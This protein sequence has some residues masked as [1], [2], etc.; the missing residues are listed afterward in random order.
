MNRKTS[1]YLLP[2]VLV[3]GLLFAA[4]ASADPL[5]PTS[6]I[7]VNAD[8]EHVNAEDLEVTFEATDNQGFASEPPQN[9]YTATV[10]DHT[11]A[12]VDAV[13]T[14]YQ[15]NY[16]I[17]ADTDDTLPVELLNVNVSFATQE[18]V[19]GELTEGDID[20]DNL[21]GST[22]VS[23]LR[24]NFGNGAGDDADLDEDDI[25][26]STDVSLIRTNFGESFTPAGDDGSRSAN[27]GPDGTATIRWSPTAIDDVPSGTVVRYDVFVDNPTGESI[28]TVQIHV[29]FDG[30]RLDYVAAR[31]GAN[32]GIGGG[33]QAGDCD[34]ENIDAMQTTPGDIG[35][36][37]V[38]A[39]E[40]FY[41]FSS[42]EFETGAAL[43]VAELYFRTTVDITDNLEAVRFIPGDATPGVLT[44]THYVYDDLNR[45]NI[46]QEFQN[47]DFDTG[48]CEVVA[49]L[50]VGL[51]EIST[52]Q[53]VV[54]S[55][56]ALIAVLGVA[57]LAVTR[58]AR[59]D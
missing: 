31:V 54:T 13:G 58:K 55:I 43:K 2:L 30:A 29:D 15:G 4:V 5:A 7:S 26:G 10:V 46:A 44:S 38:A 39:D 11:S 22:D 42:N 52:Q 53:T 28:N 33:C 16:N 3:L 57:T 32:D 25:V 8:F 6:Q 36:T 40:V 59:Q 56:V 14:F 9:P 24:G 48:N 51:S 47:C 23:I 45:T 41:T 17:T 34:F 27:R 50:N 1:R 21:V 37:T 18:I 12:G 49:F 35:N 19:F 20:D